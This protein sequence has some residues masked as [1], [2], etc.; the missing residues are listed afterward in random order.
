MFFG[1][2]GF[3]RRWKALVLTTCLVSSTVFS[4]ESFVSLAS[5]VQGSIPQIEER[6]TNEE[7]SISNN[8]NNNLPSPGGDNSDDKNET[9][10]FDNNRRTLRSSAVTQGNCG[11]K[12]GGEFS[13][14]VTWELDNGTLTISGNGEMANFKNV[15]ATY[16]GGTLGELCN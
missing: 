8:S 7:E 5:E 10:S 3:M 12:S 16:G 4:N 15:T 14:S 11:A 9:Y 13:D 1:G 2:K 6:Q